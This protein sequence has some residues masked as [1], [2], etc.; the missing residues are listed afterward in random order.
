[1]GEESLTQ[2]LCRRLGGLTWASPPVKKVWFCSYSTT[3]LCLFLLLVFLVLTR[4]LSNASCDK[5][6][7]LIF[8]VVAYTFS[9]FV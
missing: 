6:A 7:Q 4:L 9:Q 8:A 2:I 1:M 3:K 5:H